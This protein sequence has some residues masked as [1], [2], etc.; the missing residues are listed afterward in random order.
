MIKNRNK[1][2]QYKDPLSFNTTYFELINFDTNSNFEHSETF[3]NRPY[4]DPN[5]ISEP[6]PDKNNLQMILHDTRHDTSYSNQH[7][8]T[9]LFQD[10]EPT[11]S[12]TI[13]DPSET[14]TIQNTSEL[15]QE[16]TNDPQI[17]T[18][19]SNIIQIPVHTIIQTNIN[20]PPSNNT[21][22]N[23]HED[24]TSTLSTSNTLRLQLKNFIHNKQNNQ[25]MI[26]LLFLYKIFLVSH[27]I[28]LLNKDRQTHKS[29]IQYNIE[30]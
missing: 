30:P 20:N 7:E 29:Q 5:F 24:T 17:V 3:D 25:I 6:S 2:I 13:P 18:D 16:T 22:P 9:N 8:I 19:D 28:I 11:H 4:I 1:H 26:H 27:H 21:T 15:S 12:N 23:P 10:Q 14:A